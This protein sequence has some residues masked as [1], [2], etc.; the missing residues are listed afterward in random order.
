MSDK[1]KTTITK[2][3]FEATGNITFEEQNTIDQNELTKSSV[4]LSNQNQWTAWIKLI[5]SRAK[6]LKVWPKVKPGSNLP[7]LEE[8]TEPEVPSLSGHDSYAGIDEPT[9]LRHL[10]VNGLKTY[11]KEMAHY[12]TRIESFKIKQH[13][14]E[15]ETKGLDILTNLIQS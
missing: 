4:I 11:E 5:T 7:L 3:L 12:R 13:R 1:I 6:S 2:C 15:Q 14:Y 10:T 9:E 8:P